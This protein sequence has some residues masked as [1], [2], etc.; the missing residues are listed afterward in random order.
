MTPERALQM[1]LERAQSRGWAGHDPYDGLLSP[2]GRLA[3]S[4]GAGPRIFITQAT[5]RSATFRRLTCP[6]ESVN[7]K[8]LSLFLGA[9]ARGGA[10][11]G[12]DVV[13][14]AVQELT[15]L[16]DSTAIR[17]D[18]WVAWGYP[19][20]W[21][22]RFFY[23]P[24]G[25][26]NAVVTATAGWNLL[27][28]AE[29]TGDAGA[30]ELAFGAARFLSFG[31]NH[32]PIGEA[33]SALSYTPNDRAHIVNVSMLGARLLAR[34]A[35]L[36]GTDGE[37]M[38]GQ[39]RRLLRFTL[40]SQRDDGAWTYAVEKR[41]GWI[42]SFHTGFILEGLL[43]MRAFGYSV[44][45]AAVS[46]GFT[47]YRGFFDEGGGG[48]I[49]ARRNAPYD[50]HSAAQGIITYA[51]LAEAGVTDDRASAE[52]RDRAL[53]IARWS[54]ARLWLPRKGYFAYRITRGKTD[55]QEYT[56]WVQAWM[57]LGMSAAIA[58]ERTETLFA[59]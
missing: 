19:F 40:D 51:R 50:A 17:R 33:A 56:R 12:Q 37:R 9:I 58:M 29:H 4:F 44:P 57:A 39:A 52:A 31:L 32:T 35:P 28:W 49:W 27:N 53:R 42:D 7:P 45:E 21:Q 16:L 1:V 34:A 2:L 26:P 23:A 59:R 36:A 5:L 11:L 30:R 38:S 24:I 22:S 25:T 14:P 41:G 18:G 8:G 54:L 43:D 55:E 10:V 3:A 15:T 46:R 20:P 48:R 13:K 47:F 6:P